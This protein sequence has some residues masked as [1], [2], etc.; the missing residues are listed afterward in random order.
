MCR[1]IYAHLTDGNTAFGSRCGV[2]FYHSIRRNRYSRYIL[3]KGT[4]LVKPIIDISTNG[5]AG[6][7]NLYTVAFNDRCLKTGIIDTVC[8]NNLTLSSIYLGISLTY[9]VGRDFYCGIILCV[10]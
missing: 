9:G 2:C 10:G 4:L 1:V 3:C 7:R 5:A 6:N 8:R